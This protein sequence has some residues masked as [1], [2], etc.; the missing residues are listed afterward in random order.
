MKLIE[1]E[2]GEFPQ[3]DH[4]NPKFIQGSTRLK[5]TLE[6]STNG[7]GKGELRNH[8][9]E[10]TQIF[11]RFIKHR[12]DNEHGLSTSFQPKPGLKQVD[13]A[14]D[15]AH[16]IEHMVIDLQCSLSQ[17]RSCSG[18][19]CAYWNPGNRYDLFVECADP[20]VGIFAL[21]FAKEIVEGILAEDRVDFKY[22][23]ILQLAKFMQK[24]TQVSHDVKGLSSALMWKEETVKAYLKELIRLGYL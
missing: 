2:W 17:M 4:L 24:N 22:K 7:L 3:V 15:V 10:L 11:P 12:C 18:I 19:T 13:K 23:K 5:A 14:T 6:I 9:R 8:I 21:R 16:L 1:F 20:K